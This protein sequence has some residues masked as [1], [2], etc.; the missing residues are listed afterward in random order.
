[1]AA[2]LMKKRET[3]RGGGVFGCTTKRFFKGI[4][5]TDGDPVPGPGEYMQ[6][7]VCSLSVALSVARLACLVAVTVA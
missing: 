4:V 7:R 3:S 5:S 1:M 2:E 6:V